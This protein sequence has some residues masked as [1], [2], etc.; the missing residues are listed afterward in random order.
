MKV[1]RKGRMWTLA[2]GTT[3]AL[4]GAA[5]G[6]GGAVA[7][8]G[9]SGSTTTTTKTV[10]VRPPA[11]GS[12]GSHRGAGRFGGAFKN[13]GIAG[14]PVHA[15]LTVPASGGGFET[16]TV[17]RGT[18]SS[19][20]GSTLTITEGIKGQTR[21]ATITVPSG[22][23]IIRNFSTAQLSDL[24]QGDLVTVIQTPKGAVVT[25]ADASAKGHGPGFRGRFPGHDRRGSQHGTFHGSF[26]GA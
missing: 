21:T 17:D 4:G 3:A 22:A 12:K 13:L 23:K 20:S 16:A 11:A 14:P 24:K 10:R 15:T 18:V 26:F 1:M 19:V 6:I 8:T 9:K 25:A 7:S 5:F 2:V